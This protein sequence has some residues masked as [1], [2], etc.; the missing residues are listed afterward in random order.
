MTADGG[1]SS[2]ISATR[3]GLVPAKGGAG[4]GRKQQSSLR[5]YFGFTAP[6]APSP[7]SPT[8][9]AAPETP[10]QSQGGDTNTRVVPGEHRQRKDWAGG[11]EKAQRRGVEPARTDFSEKEMELFRKLTERYQS[12][13]SKRWVKISQAWDKAIQTWEG[14]E[15]PYQPRT[16]KQFNTYFYGTWARHLER[17]QKRQKPDAA[18]APS[19][20]RQKRHRRPRDVLDPSPAPPQHN[21]RTALNPP[22]QPDN[23]QQPAD[24][25]QQPAD[26]VQQPADNVQQPPDNVQQQDKRGQSQRER[27]MQNRAKGIYALIMHVHVHVYVCVCVCVCMC[28]CVHHMCANPHCFFSFSLFS[29]LG[30]HSSLS[31]LPVTESPLTVSPCVLGQLACRH[32]VLYA[33]LRLLME[34]G[35]SPPVLA[36]HNGMETPPCRGTLVLLSMGKPVLRCVHSPRG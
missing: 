31:Q 27:R 30:C 26:N 3:S 23:V 19:D 25:V 36:C 4:K 5:S 34:T 9:P 33:S 35:G 13:S 1:E 8:S 22:S 14:E 28:V 15:C 10:I 16:P 6:A 17:E 2:P 7:A 18:D 11:M 24:N 21:R 20:A 32:S 12:G 29:F